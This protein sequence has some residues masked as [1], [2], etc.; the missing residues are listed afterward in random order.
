MSCTKSF[1]ISFDASSIP[2]VN[3]T[4]AIGVKR[5]RSF[6]PDDDISE[7]ELIEFANEALRKNKKAKRKRRKTKKQQKKKRKTLRRRKLHR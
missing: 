4:K 3:Q 2:N 1:I 5:S 6:D 7:E